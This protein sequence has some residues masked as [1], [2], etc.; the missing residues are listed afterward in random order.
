MNIASHRFGLLSYAVLRT[1]L[2]AAFAA[3]AVS[4]YAAQGGSS[5]KPPDTWVKGHILV[6][7]KAGLSDAE[8]DKTLAAQG[9]KAVGR[10]NS[11]NIYVVSLPATASEQAVA[12][13]LAH[14]PNIKFA[15]VDRLVPPSLVTN[16]AYYSSE[17]HLQTIGA[18]TAWNSSIG[19]GVTVAILDSGVD[20]T[21]PDLQG[22]LVPGWNFYDNNS[23]TSDVYGHGTLV[24]GVVGAIGNN[25]IGVAGVAWGARIMPVRVTD[26][27]GIGSYKS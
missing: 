19:A 10:L 9:G 1:V 16:D 4:A 2:L 20:A 5:G 23:N 7:P 14:H 15:E 21:H 12:N 17:W 11:L 26:T 22:Q 25:G 18:P 6:Q 27:S 3:L 8:F 24:A 13:A